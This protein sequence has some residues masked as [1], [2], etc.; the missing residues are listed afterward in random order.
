MDNGSGSQFGNCSGFE[1]NEMVSLNLAFSVSGAVCC[2]ISCVITLLLLISKSY[3]TVLQRLLLYLMIATTL[4]ELFTA[5]S[6][7]H[8]FKYASQL[9]EKVCTGVG[10]LFNW[11]IFLR[12]MFIVGIMFYLFCLVRYQ[13][14]GNTVPHFLQSKHRR[15]SLELAYLIL[16]P[17]LTFIYSLVPLITDNYG[18]AG[19]WCWIR[20]LDASSA[21]CKM[22]L[23]GFLNQIFNGYLLFISNGIIG[24][25]LT[26]AVAIVYCRLPLSLQESR[27][28]LKR[29]LFVMLFFFAYSII[30]VFS[31]SN[32]IITADL[33][34]YEHF[35]IW[36]TVGVTYPLSL[37]L[38]PIAFLFSFYPIKKLL[39]ATL[40]A[41]CAKRK[42]TNRQRVR[43]QQRPTNTQNVPTCP[44]SSRVSPPS[45]TFFHVP[46]TN[47][48]TRITTENAHLVRREDTG[49][50]N[51][52]LVLVKGTDTGYGSF[53]N[54]QESEMS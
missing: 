17:V 47:D 10:F 6:I 35:A 53:S 20:A 41:R 22:L 28:L 2:L 48:F 29:T 30:Q 1:L 3:H 37:L 51:A 52:S 7:E 4:A 46:Y 8:H 54:Q 11:T 34:H 14:K 27:L 33:T 16:S 21:D 38:F 25:V 24:I 9:Q 44:E 31:L 40:C 39:R 50:E 36:F 42:P 23:S 19:A 13:A 26:I 15:V 12:I 18:L 32:R 49:G 43:I 5:A 45:H